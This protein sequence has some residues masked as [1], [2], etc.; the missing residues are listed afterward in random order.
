MNSPTPRFYSVPRRTPP[1]AR[2][3]ARGRAL[4]NRLR[5]PEDPSALALAGAGQRLEVAHHVE[6]FGSLHRQALLRLS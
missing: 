6:D 1:R 2:S 3:L 4:R 5:R